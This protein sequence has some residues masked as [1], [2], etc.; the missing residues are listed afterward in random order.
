[1]YRFGEDRREAAALPVN[2]CDLNT[3]FD[4]A[5]GPNSTLP[6]D[7]TAKA[8][9]ALALLGTPAEDG[10]PVVDRQYVMEHLDLPGRD[11]VLRRITEWKQAQMQ[12]AS[13]QAAQQFS[14]AAGLT[15]TPALQPLPGQA[16]DSAPDETFRG[17]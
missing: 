2:L 16:P 12:G 5:I 3:T 15:G 4:I 6:A 14:G 8:N 1:V 13:P 17:V 7:R 11:Q 9:L 10:L